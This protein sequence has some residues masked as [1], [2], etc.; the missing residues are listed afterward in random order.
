MTERAIEDEMKWRCHVWLWGKR[1]GDTWCLYVFLL[2]AD[3]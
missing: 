2:L 1:G 3:E